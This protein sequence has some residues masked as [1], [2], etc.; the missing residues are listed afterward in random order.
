[1]LESPR[2][3][4]LPYYAGRRRS[5]RSSACRWSRGGRRAA[6][7]SATA[8]TVRKF[9]RGR[10]RAGGQRRARRSC[11]SSSPSACSRRSSARSTSTSASTSASAELNRALT[12]DQVYDAAIAG[13]RGVCEF[14]F[15]A[16]RHLR[17]RRGSHTIRR[18]VGEGADKLLG[19]THRDPS[20]IA[21][22]VAKNKLA[23]PAGGDWRE[24]DVPVF[25]HPMRIKDYESLLVVP[26][27]VKDE[28]IGTFTVAATRAGAFPSDRR[29]MLGV[30]A[31]QVAISMQ[32][33]R[34]YE[35]LEEQATTDGLTGLVNHRTFQE[36]FTTMLGRAERHE[37]R[38]VA[39]AHRHRSLQEGQRH[40]RPPDRRRG[41]AARGRDPQGERAQDRHRRPLRRRGVR[42]SSS[43]G[44]TARAR[45]SWPSAS[46]RRSRRRRSRRARAPSAR[47]CRSASPATPTIRARRPRSSRAPTRPSTRQA[48]RPQPDGLLQRHRPEAEGRGREV[49]RQRRWAAWRVAGGL[50]M[51]RCATERMPLDSSAAGGQSAPDGSIRL[52]DTRTRAVVAHGTCAIQSATAMTRRRS[53]SWSRTAARCSIRASR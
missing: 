39:A 28:V 41:A 37:L 1:M 42:A 32:N 36:R 45:A 43:R 20:S 17:G 35:V 31:N 6:S 11:A 24:R 48:R 16:H 34:M 22:M 46:A 12:L 33:A 50:A 49:T 13:A 23:L 3:S 18:V 15:A 30:I 27:L 2:L 47:R 51:A 14:D 29:E 38:R 5:A 7:W 21:S 10:R 25:S 9:E 52:L 53:P 44:P 19:T 40:L 26:L 8:P 4:L